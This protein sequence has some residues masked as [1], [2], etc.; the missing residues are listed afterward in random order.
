MLAII[1]VT[2]IYIFST[3]SPE[4]SPRVVDEVGCSSRFDLIRSSH[5]IFMKQIQ[6]EKLT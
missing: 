1:T 2:T 6:R 5:K 3:T 4:W